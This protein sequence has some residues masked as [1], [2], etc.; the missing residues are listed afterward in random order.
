MMMT[1]AQEYRLRARDVSEEMRRQQKMEPATHNY[2]EDLPPWM[3][4]DPMFNAIWHEIKTWDVNVPTEYSG[5][6]GATGSH[7]AAIL[8]AIIDKGL[9][10]PATVGNLGNAIPEVRV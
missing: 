4:Y 8:T 2:I 7:V 6:C 1:E 3:K 5:Y 10:I 9:Y